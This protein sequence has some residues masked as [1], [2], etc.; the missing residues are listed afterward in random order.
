MIWETRKEVCIKKI[1][2]SAIRKYIDNSLAKLTYMSKLSCKKRHISC[3]KDGFKSFIF[4]PLRDGDIL[5]FP[6]M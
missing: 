2:D 3:I 5:F 4:L 1:F 6:W